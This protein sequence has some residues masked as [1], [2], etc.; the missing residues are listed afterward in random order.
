MATVK[1]YLYRR[2]Y[3]KRRDSFEVAVVSCTIGIIKIRAALLI[4]Y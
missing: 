3:A 1:L 4:N 2:E